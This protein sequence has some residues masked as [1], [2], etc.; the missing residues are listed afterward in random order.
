MARHQPVDPSARAISSMTWSVV[1]TSAPSPPSAL[2]QGH[3][4]EPRPRDLGDEGGGQLA[5]RLDLL[6]RL[7]DAGR[8]G[9][10]HLE[11]PGGGG[12]AR[13]DLGHHGRLL[14]AAVTRRAP[15]GGRRPAS[16]PST[17]AGHR[18]RAQQTMVGPAFERGEV[19]V[20][21]VLGTLEAPDVIRHCAKAQV[22]RYAVPRRE[23]G[24]GSMHEA[25]MEQDHGARR[26]FR[27]RDAPR[28]L[29]AA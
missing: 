14:C 7:A 6:G 27:R 9:S 26:P 4:E 17:A 1:T 23:V 11:R 3:A 16:R 24:G 22:H 20:R 29:R 19:A 15:A 10:R 28:V 2:G 25:G 8:E 21:D 13:A 12:D 18:S 5:R